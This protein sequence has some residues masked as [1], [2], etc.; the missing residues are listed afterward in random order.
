MRAVLVGVVVAM[1]AW[2]A[3]SL[4]VAEATDVSFALKADSRGWDYGQPGGINPALTVI[5][6]DTITVTIEWVDGVHNFAVYGPGYPPNK[7]YPGNPEAIVRSGN[8]DDSTRVAS[9][10]FVLDSGGN[11]EYFSE[12]SPATMV[13]ALEVGPNHVPSLS[14]IGVTPDPVL[15]TQAV[16]FRAEANDSDGDVLSY[17]WDF[18]DGAARSGQSDPYGGTISAVHAYD[19]VGTYD[20]TLRVEDGRGGSAASSGRASVVGATTPPALLRVRTE[21]AVPATIYVNGIPRD[22]WGL[23]W[24][25]MAPG[26]YLVSFGD[27][28]GFRTPGDVTVELTSGET[29]EVV[30]TYE[31]LGYLR[32]ILQ[33]WVRAMIFVN[34]VPAAETGL[35]VAV[36]AGTYT[37]TFGRVFGADPPGPRTV[38]VVAG[39]LTTTTGVF[40]L[41]PS[42]PGPNTTGL[43]YLAAFGSPAVPTQIAVDGIPRNDWS[44]RLLID[45]GPHTVSFTDVPGYTTPPPISVTVAAGDQTA[46]ADFVAHGALHVATSPA[47]PATVFVDGVPRNDWALDLTLLPQDYVVSFGAVPGYFTPAPQVVR[48][49]AGGQV[50]VRGEYVPAQAGPSDPAPAADE[51]APAIVGPLGLIPSAARRRTD[52]PRR[53]GLALLAASVES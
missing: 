6:H 46:R 1:S 29:T 15:P 45:Q 48:I 19:A 20:V 42:A 32:V 3:V 43:G 36:P 14:A 53:A 50:S 41:N 18:G 21:P 44:V 2:A 12:F 23:A 31:R 35:W 25:K 13:G 22:R 38:A 7:V 26:A 10:A 8:V 4:P 40:T 52:A 28:P 27:V 37:V 9:V 11:Y 51:S 17:V 24:V 33:P 16:S 30:G 34:G 39:Q 5:A 47:L 49:V